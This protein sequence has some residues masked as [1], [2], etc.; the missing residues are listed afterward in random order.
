MTR[1]AIKNQAAEAMEAAKPPM[2]RWMIWVKKRKGR[3]KGG[4]KRAS[5]RAGADS[6][7]VR[8]IP[9]TCAARAHTF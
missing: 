8:S 6:R 1:T 5:V 7:D 4:A 2:L 3:G 9:P